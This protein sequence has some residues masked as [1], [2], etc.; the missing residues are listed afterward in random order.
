MNT[1]PQRGENDAVCSLL[2]ALSNAA[3]GGQNSRDSRR[4]G[5]LQTPWLRAA[6]RA[7]LP[8]GRVSRVVGLFFASPLAGR[9]ISATP[10]LSLSSRFGSRPAR[11]AGLLNSGYA[12]RHGA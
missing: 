6:I 1:Q 9:N 5:T 8:A 11:L 4:D 12:R 2:P 7:A 10:W 3:I